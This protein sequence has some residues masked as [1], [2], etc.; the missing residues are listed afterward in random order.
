[1]P[2]PTP[3]DWRARATLLALVTVGYNLVEGLV[4]IHFGLADESVALWGFGFDSFIEVASALLV[5]WRIRAGLGNRGLER[6]LKATRAIGWL[7]L[8]LALS[9][10]LGSAAAL[11]AHRSP[12][13]TLPGVIISLVSIALMA[14]LWRAKL[15]VAEVS[16]S[17]TLKG[18]AA[19]S[20]A[21][22][23]L[24]TVLLVGSAAYALL[25][26]LWWVDSAA[27]ILLALLIGREGREMVKSTSVAAACGG[28]GGGCGCG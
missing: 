17:P 27:A 1:M 24:S 9:I 22:I 4:S 7:F 14:W 3:T 18:D 8:L 25:P 11:M 16:G 15:R 10:A 19:C 28:C 6:E 13:T 2:E 23:L 5:L 20:R 21:C 12:A 26:A